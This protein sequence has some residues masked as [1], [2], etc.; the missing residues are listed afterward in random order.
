[1]LLA[2]VWR[3]I[4]LLL[5]DALLQVAILMIQVLIVQIDHYGRIITLHGWRDGFG[6]ESRYPRQL[7]ELYKISWVV[8]LEKQVYYVERIAGYLEDWIMSWETKRPPPL[9]QRANSRQG[10]TRPYCYRQYPMVKR[11]RGVKAVARNAVQI[12]CCVAV[13]MAADANNLGGR[14]LVFD[15]DAT[16]LRIYNCLTAT[17]S[18]RVE[19][20]VGPLIPV[21]RKVKGVGGFLNDIYE[22]TFLL[23]IEDDE[24]K[25]HE[26][27][28]PKLFYVP[29]ATTRLLSPQHWAQVAED[30]SPSPRG[31]WCATYGD[32]IVLQWD[33]RQ[34]TKTLAL[35]VSGA[36]VATMFD[37]PGYRQFGKRAHQGV[38]RVLRLHHRS[39][40]T[41]FYRKRHDG[42]CG[43]VHV[44]TLVTKGKG[45][46]NPILNYL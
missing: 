38:V 42:S 29:Q 16:A 25:T 33:Q 34:Y 28:L 22:G 26:V 37:A 14:K 23:R 5:L 41:K 39:D 12:I 21:N 20:F 4:G 32:S 1:M 27:L 9:Q 31:T 7:M 43:L 44:A 24:G 11:N 17:L 46:I 3:E 18:N 2:W 19:D 30:N 13:A 36:N 15:T 35:D 8:R 10:R 40:H 6:R 45:S